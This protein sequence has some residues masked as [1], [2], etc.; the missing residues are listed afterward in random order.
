[1]LLVSQAAPPDRADPEPRGE[2]GPC[3]QQLPPVGADAAEPRSR[4]SG[5]RRAEAR[6]SAADPRSARPCSCPRLL[7][8]APCTRRRKP[9]VRAPR[10]GTTLAAASKG[11]SRNPVLPKHAPVAQLDRA[12]D[13][14]SGGQRFESF[15]ARQLNQVLAQKQRRL[16]NRPSEPIA[17][18]FSRSGFRQSLP[19][20]RAVR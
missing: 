6:R 9:L 20:F 11:Q 10:I 3:F 19:I 18:T 17:N 16:R 5:G 1:M 12:P 8:D 2:R 15:R 13:Y 4:D 7:V 14:E